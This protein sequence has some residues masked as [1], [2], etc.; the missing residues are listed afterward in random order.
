[1]LKVG[2]RSPEF[3]G[4]D[5]RSRSVAIPELVL[6]GP[7]VVYFYPKSFALNCTAQTC[8]FR[9]AYLEF[10]SMGAEVVG[11]SL[12]PP[13]EQQDFAIEFR[14]PFALL[15]D[16]E[17]NLVELFDVL[18]FHRLFPKRVTYVIDQS[19]IIRGVFHHELDMEKHVKEVRDLLL[20]LQTERRE[21][22]KEILARLRE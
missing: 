14:V 16:Q 15:S 17:K 12:D 7:V 2:D 13:D 22:N 20:V 1:M 5:H 8:S 6:R 18:H 19:M 3:S 11:V 4:V 21:A 9:N 10:K